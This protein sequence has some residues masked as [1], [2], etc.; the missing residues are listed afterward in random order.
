[1]QHMHTIVKRNK[2]CLEIRDI[3]QDLCKNKHKG[4]NGMTEEEARAE[5]EEAERLIAEIN[6]L[7]RQIERATVDNRNLQA[8]L[9][10]LV[11]DV[12][13]LASNTA[14][15]DGEVNRSMESVKNRI[16]AADVSTGEL[17]ALIDDLT[18]SYFIF[19][20]LSAAS[21]K[22]TQYT[23]EYF[24]RFGLFHELRRISLGYVIGLDAHICSD[25]TMRKKVEKVYLQNTEYWLAYAIMAV[26]LW[27]GDEKEAAERAMSKA[28]SMD[29]FSS[30]L[31]FLLINLRFT[32]VEAAKKWYLSYLDRVD[33]ENLGNEWQYLLQAYLSGVFGVDREFNHLVQECFTNMLQQMESMHPN[34]GSRVI[35]KTLSYSNT[36]I[37]VTKN[38][39]ETL[40]RN[41]PEYEEMKS[42]LSAAE[43]NEMLALHIRESLQEESQIESDMFQR[44]ENILYDLINAYDKEEFKVIKNKRYNEMVIKANGD[45]GMAQQFYN[46]EYPDITKTQSLEDLLFDWAFEEDSLRVDI[47]VK[48]FALYYLKKWIVKGFVAYGEGYRKREK[49]TYK[50][51]IDG[52]ERECNENAYEAARDELE[53]HYNQN[54]VLDTIKDKYVLIFMGM[55]VT[56][57]TVLGIT[58]FKFNKIALVIGI[59]LGVV[60]GFLLWRRISDMQTIL[61]VKREK[62]C[63][64]LKK[65]LEELKSWRELYKL[66]NAKNADLTDVFKHIEI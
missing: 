44:I 64:L 11:R 40:R 65:A 5:R 34:Y 51:S 26:M 20:N 42:L 57:L 12:E 60:S 30:S 39:F 9:A 29:Y 24:T 62:G 56:A 45:L 66:E 14:A 2:R 7:S 28:L 46:N 23:D 63:E 32:R 6:R 25:E 13:I 43:K 47:T 1:M 37:Y 35:E 8:E 16:Y 50:I 17:F 49:E 53:K 55:A 36:Y 58:M 41:C 3:L 54:R 22:V 48:K 38:E 4:G 27:A 52:W 21:K 19:K 61:R 33:M 18:H 10:S 15:M 59:L 31:F